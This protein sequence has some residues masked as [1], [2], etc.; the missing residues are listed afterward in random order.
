MSPSE[1]DTIG[2]YPLALSEAAKFK[3]LAS[4]VAPRRTEQP[5]A[6]MSG[7]AFSAWFSL[8]HRQSDW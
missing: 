5:F 4:I 7:T 2:Q 3:K 6:E 8:L 1:F